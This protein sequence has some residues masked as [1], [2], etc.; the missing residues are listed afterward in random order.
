M[1]SNKYMIGT[2]AM[3]YCS[4]SSLITA[5]KKL[6]LNRDV[7]TQM[8]LYLLPDRIK[9]N[10]LWEGWEESFMMQCPLWVHLWLYISCSNDSGTQKIFSADS[11][12]SLSLF[13]SHPRNWNSI[14]EDT[15]SGAAVEHN[16][17]WLGEACPLRS[18]EEMKTLLCFPDHSGGVVSGGQVI[19]QKKSKE[20]GALDSLNN[21]TTDD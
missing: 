12:Q 14:C 9:K 20:S 2:A 21:R 8:L 15:L 19:T 11:A 7:L 18:P 1:L 6:F 17:G 3:T 5:G 4:F 16:H 13:C 10:R